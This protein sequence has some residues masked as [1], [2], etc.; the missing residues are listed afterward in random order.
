MLKMPRLQWRPFKGLAV[1]AALVGAALPAA[2]HPHMCVALEATV[3]YEKGGFTG[4]EQK[5]TFSDERYVAEAVEGLDKN[6]DG[7]LDRS[8]LDELAKVNVESLQEF[9]YFT[10][11]MVAGQPVK[12]AQAKDYWMEHTATTLSLHFTVPFAAPVPVG[13]KALE[14]IVRDPENFIAFGLQ[15]VP[16]SVRLGSGT[17]KSCRVSAVPLKG[18][19]QDMLKQILEAIGCAITVP[20]AITVA[21]DGP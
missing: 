20:K 4:L 15:K 2:A 6:K 1:S 9:D 10:V 3:I 12:V 14:F 11:P 16:A 5:W 18:E 8:E 17:P 19:E 7:K 21:C 13:D